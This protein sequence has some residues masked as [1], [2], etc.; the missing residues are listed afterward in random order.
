MLRHEHIQSASSS[1]FP[2]EIDN[3]AAFE[4]D[5]DTEDAVA[6]APLLIAGFERTILVPGEEVDATAM[7]CFSLDQTAR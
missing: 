7:A 5:A 6:M 1:S 3:V 4:I 2:C